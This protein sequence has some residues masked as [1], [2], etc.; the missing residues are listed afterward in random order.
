MR[1]YVVGGYVRDKLLGLD[2]HDRDW[3]VVGSTPE[4]MLAQGFEQVG[5]EFPVFLHPETCEHYA[6]ARRERKVRPGHRG[7]EVD[8]GPEVTLVEDLGRRDLT[9]NAI[10]M[11]GDELI[12]PLGGGHDLAIKMLRAVSPS[13]FADDPLRVVRLARF[14]AML[15]EFWT[16]Q[17]TLDL[18]RAAG[19]ELA[20]LTPERLYGETC[21]ALLTAKPSRFFELLRFCGALEPTF[22]EVDRLVGASQ[23]PDYHPEG[24][25]FAHSMLV[26]D[27]MAK[28][29]VTAVDDA[30]HLCGMFAA[31]YH[32]VGKGATP[33]EELPHH[34]AHEKTGAAIA[35]EALA[36]LRAPVA[37]ARFVA[38]AVR[39]HMRAHRWRELRSRTVLGIF[40]EIGALRDPL[41]LVLF[42]RVAYADSRG[43]ELAVER[44]ELAAREDFF[45]AALDAA[46][47]IRGADLIAA[48]VPPG[49]E[50]GQ[51]GP[52]LR[53]AR[54]KAIN[55]VRREHG[56]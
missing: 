40:D 11:D 21:R 43:R 52:R 41:K 47:A 28:G 15:P 23:H 37:L 53:E 31:L 39:L 46:S 27:E 48:G 44:A 18:A 16:Q 13:S 14:A 24:D 45:R 7:F 17:A 2:P 36:R 5:A 51:V 4:E 33:V 19:P 50:P 38:A 42:L 56:L 29:R 10:A 54:I 9:I 32:D 1:A 34:Y 35:G 22:P 25:A 30:W 6:L 12:D 8:F 20:S 3:V 55:R 49:P 26:L